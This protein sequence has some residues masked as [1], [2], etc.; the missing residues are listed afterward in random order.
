ME[1]ELEA[2]AIPLL[3]L[4]LAPEEVVATTLWI[5]EA[6]TVW[7]VVLPP[8]LAQVREAVLPLAVAL[9]LVL[10]PAIIQIIVLVSSVD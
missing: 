8:D 6:P 9:A 4:A 7:A 5:V 3:A 1:Q 10:V 2:A